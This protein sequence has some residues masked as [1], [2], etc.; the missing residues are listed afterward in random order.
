[1]RLQTVRQDLVTEQQHPPWP[2]S[3][4]HLHITEYEVGKKWL[5]WALIFWC[6]PAPAHP[7]LHPCD[8]NS[9]H[10]VTGPATCPS[11][12]SLYLLCFPLPRDFCAFCSFCPGCTFLPFHLINI[13][14]SICSLHNCDFLGHTFPDLPTRSSNLSLD[15]HHTGHFPSLEYVTD[16]ILHLFNSWY[17]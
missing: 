15:S 10:S 5:Q 11:F 1:M 12:N 8:S 14:S 2:I 6:K 7:A 16:I 13:G 9:F 3:S 17:D 4:Y